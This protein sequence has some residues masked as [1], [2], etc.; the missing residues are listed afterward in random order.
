M[1]NLFCVHRSGDRYSI[2]TATRIIAH[3]VTR[4]LARSAIAA[5]I[6]GLS[7]SQI[8]Q[9]L[10]QPSDPAT[11]RAT[12]ASA[13]AAE[14]EQLRSTVD[15][16]PTSEVVNGR[17]D[18]LADYV[19]ALQVEIQ[20][21]RNLSELRELEQA[22]EKRAEKAIAGMAAAGFP[23]ADAVVWQEL[24]SQRMGQRVTAL[25]EALTQ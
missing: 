14:L 11:Y 5:A 9:S 10:D 21:E 6:D 24:K 13:C 15:T 7:V 20:R 4:K 12:F 25:R 3:N 16:L 19:A 8:E 17:I 2:V 1:N 18:Q 22:L 23:N